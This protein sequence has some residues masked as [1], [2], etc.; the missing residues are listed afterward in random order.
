MFRL[1]PLRM[2]ICI[3]PRSLRHGRPV[4]SARH[5]GAPPKSPHRPLRASA[6]PDPPDD[7]LH[8]GIGRRHLGPC[9]TMVLISGTVLLALRTSNAR[10]LTIRVALGLVAIGIASSLIAAT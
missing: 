1:T 4:S 3:S 10:P 9:G 2:T 6:A 5:A 8:L 7:R